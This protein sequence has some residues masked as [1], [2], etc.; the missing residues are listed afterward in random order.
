VFVPMPTLPLKWIGALRGAGSD[1][2]GEAL[3][4]KKSYLAG[5]SET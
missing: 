1:T 5:E 2:H 3:A 4:G